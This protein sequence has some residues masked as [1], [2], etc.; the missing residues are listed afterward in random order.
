MTGDGGWPIEATACEKFPSAASRDDGPN[1]FFLLLLCSMSLV[2]RN[3][4]SLRRTGGIEFHLPPNFHLSFFFWCFSFAPLFFVLFLFVVGF[5]QSV[6]P[7][8]VTLSAGSGC[9][10]RVPPERTKNSLEKKKKSNQNSGFLRLGMLQ[11]VRWDLLVNWVFLEGSL[12]TEKEDW[13]DHDR[14]FD[15]GA[16][17]GP[18]LPPPSGR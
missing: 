2:L 13:R 17:M 4:W 3:C 5:E 10:V 8:W 1:F 9:S 14:M 16:S 6:H 18:P 12:R 11:W 7:T 15:G